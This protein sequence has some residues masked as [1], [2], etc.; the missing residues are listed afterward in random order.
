MTIKSASFAAAKKAA[1]AILL[2][3]GM[4]ASNMAHA[5]W[6]TRFLCSGDNDP[7]LCMSHFSLAVQNAPLPAYSDQI[8]S[9]LTQ[10][11]R[12]QGAEKTAFVEKNSQMLLGVPSVAQKK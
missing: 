1:P 6:L 5:N 3:A 2:C 7:K 11:S 9:I 8:A 12:L 4:L 10:A